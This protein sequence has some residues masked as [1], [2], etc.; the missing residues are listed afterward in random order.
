[1][2]THKFRILAIEPDTRC[3]EHLRA[4]LDGRVEADL[5]IVASAD[6]A[7]GAIHTNRPD[8]VLTSAVLPPA[9]KSR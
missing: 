9:P 5:V 6:A 4:L 7:A 3:R 2:D 8:L 1:M